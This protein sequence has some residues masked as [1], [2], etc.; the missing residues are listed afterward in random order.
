MH[1]AVYNSSSF[2]SSLSQNSTTG[3]KAVFSGNFIMV[4]PDGSQTHEHSVS[5]FTSNNVIIA[6]GDMIITGIGNVY[7]NAELKYIQV[8]IAVHLM[9]K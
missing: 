4:K 9:G 7:G 8:P 6:G 1:L 3:A 5:D 2:S